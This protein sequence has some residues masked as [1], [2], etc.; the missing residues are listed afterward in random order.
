MAVNLGNHVFNPD[1]PNGLSSPAATK[2]TAMTTAGVW[3]AEEG[4]RIVEF[5]K[6]VEV[7]SDKATI[8]ITSKS[9]GT[10]VKKQR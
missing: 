8:E 10:L 9:N 7:Q 6:L 2:V 3:F 5:G 1:N 4:E